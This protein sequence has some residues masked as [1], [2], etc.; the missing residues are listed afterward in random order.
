MLGTYIRGASQVQRGYIYMVRFGRRTASVLETNILLRFTREMCPD[1]YIAS[2]V[3]PLIA[4]VQ[5]VYRTKY[6]I[7]RG[8]GLRGGRG[9][10]VLRLFNGKKKS[11][12]TT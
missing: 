7:G 6:I 4:G 11:L 2:V 3:V 8:G 9:G 1:E 5:Q 10:G 12:E